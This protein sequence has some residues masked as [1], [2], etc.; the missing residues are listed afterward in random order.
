VS[1]ISA[2]EQAV[3]SPNSGDAGYDAVG[4]DQIHASH[5]AGSVEADALHRVAPPDYRLPFDDAS[6]DFVYSTSVMEHV[7]DPGKALS[8]ISRVMRVGSL[9]IHV[10]PSRWRWIE[11]HT[12]VPIGGRFQSLA[13]ME[14]WARLGLRNNFQ[15]GMSAMEVALANV[16]FCKTGAN[17]NGARM[18]CAGQ[19]VIQSCRLG[20]DRLCDGVPRRESSLTRRR[21]LI[22]WR[23][24]RSAYRATHTRVLVLMK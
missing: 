18:G 23:L 6:F 13:V 2:Q 11:P 20:R 12:Q 19:P 17:Y 14:L 24:A 3:T 21:P 5:E 4:V 1:S 10:F 8:E 16:Q 15:H 22:G 9:S 7:T